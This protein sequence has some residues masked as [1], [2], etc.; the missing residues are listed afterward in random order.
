MVCSLLYILYRLYT[1]LCCILVWHC[2]VFGRLYAL[3]LC[4]VLGV[5]V[6]FVVYDVVVGVV[7]SMFIISLAGNLPHLPLTERAG[8]P[9]PLSP[10][11]P[12]IRWTIYII[13]IIYIIFMN[14]YM[15][16]YIYIYK[17]IYMTI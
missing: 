16:I 3:L 11:A 2:V 4:D 13:Y 6:V 9:L 1:L 5:V 17:Y 15:H 12:S 8:V 14:I 7:C 10:V